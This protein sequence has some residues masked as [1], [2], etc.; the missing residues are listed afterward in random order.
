AV[1]ARPEVFAPFDRDPL[2]HAS[3]FGGNPLACAAVT[4]ALSVIESEDI[5]GRA[6]ELGKRLHPVLDGLVAGW[7]D[8]FAGVSGRGL[9]LGLICR[10]PDVAGDLY[11]AC[12]QQGLLVT[13]CLLRPDV[14]RFTPPAVLEEEELAFAEAALRAAAE[15]TA[16]EQTAG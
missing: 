10:R 2:L 6:A 14:I 15:V 13:P 11:R 1:V 8:L 9:L 16:Q 3:T 7:P 5:P 12:L 4:A